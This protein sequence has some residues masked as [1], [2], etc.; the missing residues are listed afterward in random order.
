M[1]ALQLPRDLR[2]FVPGFAPMRRLKTAQ[3][4]LPFSSC[5][6][7]CHRC[8]RYHRVKTNK[9]FVLLSVWPSLMS[10]FPSSWTLESH[11]GPVLSRFPSCACAVSRLRCLSLPLYPLPSSPH[12]SPIVAHFLSALGSTSCSLDGGKNATTL[13]VFCSPFKKKKRKTGNVFHHTS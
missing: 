8:C 12:S 4:E 3:W 6:L 7:T 1:L 10:S 11:S 2:Y 5:E 9:A 13:P